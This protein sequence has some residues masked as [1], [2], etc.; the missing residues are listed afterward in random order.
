MKTAC[1]TIV[2]HPDEK[3]LENLRAYGIISGG[4]Y[5][6]DNSEGQPDWVEQAIPNQPGIRY[7]RDGINA[8]IGARLNQACQLAIAEGAEWILTM[9]QDSY[10]APELLRNYI[11]CVVSYAG[12]EQVAMFGVAYGEEKTDDVKCV[13]SPVNK[14][15]TSGS[16]VNLSLFKRIGGFDESLFIDGVDT[17]YSF[18][19]RAAGFDLVCFNNIVLDHRIGLVSYHRSL[20]TGSLTPRSLHSPR[21]LYYMTRNYLY[22]RKKYGKKYGGMFYADL[23]EHRRILLLRIK[24]NL[25]YNRRRGSVMRNVVMGLWAFYAGKRNK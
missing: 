18:K 16:M 4:V 1:V 20:K 22:L 3:V 6:I 12:R 5:V 7:F 14:L 19:A 24:N 2:Y 17:D 25:L 13:A 23:Q 11:D 21:R 10:F 8:G 15:I 9:D